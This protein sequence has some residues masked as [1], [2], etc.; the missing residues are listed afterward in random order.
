MRSLKFT[1]EQR[2]AILRDYDA[3]VKLIAIAAEHNCSTA[4]VSNTALAT[5]RP[6]RF[7]TNPYGRGGKP[8]SC[9]QQ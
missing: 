9:N 7:T 6:R 1:D 4:Y 2:A 5:G 3:G 8:E